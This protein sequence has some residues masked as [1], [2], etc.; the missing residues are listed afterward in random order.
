MWRIYQY[1]V[2]NL[3]FKQ[4]ITYKSIHTTNKEKKGSNKNEK[5][6]KEKKKVKYMS[7]MIQSQ[8]ALLGELFEQKRK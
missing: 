7:L 2:L 4:I 6:R 8:K 3:P 5:E 1:L